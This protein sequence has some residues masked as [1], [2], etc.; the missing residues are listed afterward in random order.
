MTK[1]IHICSLNCQGLRVKDKRHRLYLW[2]KYQKC[3]ILFVQ[4]SHFTEDLEKDLNSEIKDQQY[5]S[6]GT[7]QSRGVSIFI[8]NDLECKFI[9]IFKDQEGRLLLINIEIEDSIYTLVNVYAPNIPKNRNIFFKKV[10]E[11]I[12]KNS[13]GM[14]IIGGD[15]ND[16]LTKIDKKNK[17]STQKLKQTKP[18]FSLKSLIKT[19]KLSD[20]WREIHGKEIQFTWRRKNNLN[21]ASRIDFFLTCPEIRTKIE[22]TDIRPAIITHTD[23][24]AISIKIKGRSDQ[25]GKGYFKINNSILEN[26]EYQNLIKILIKQYEKKILL[27]NDIGVK[28][29]LFK[30]EVRDHTIAFCK[31]KAQNNVKD[32]HI[33]ENKLKKLN[34]GINKKCK[35]D[36]INSL[37]EEINI[38]EEKLGKLYDS[39]TKGA[40]IRSR[41][42]WVEEG[43]KNTKFFLGLEKARQ[44]RKT[45]TALRDKEGVIHTHPTEILNIEKEFYEEIYKSSNP[46]KNSIKDYVMNTECDHVL[47]DKESDS[48]EGLLSTQECTDSLFKMKLNKAP[49][50]DGLSVEF[51]RTFWEHLKEFAVKTFNLSFD[52]G[53]LTNSQK[54]GVISLLHKKNDPLSLDN[55]RPITLLNVDT[56]LVAYSLAQRIIK[57]LPQIIH[58]DQNGYVKNRYIGYNIR[59]IQDVIDYADKFN[60][61]GALLFLDF[62]KAFDSLEWDFMFFALQKFGFKNSMMRWIKLL[63]TDIKSSV[64]NNGWISKPMSIYRGIRQGCPCSA[65]IFVIAV[66]ILACKIRQDHN[67]KG[68]EIKIDGKTHTLKISQLADDTT[69]FLKSKQDISKALNMIEKFGSL[70]GLK[71]NRSKT[72]GIWLG[73]QKHCKEKYE[74][75]NFTEK[76]IKSLGIYFGHNKKECQKLNFDKQLEKTVKI[77]SNWK[78]RN[79]T[80]IGRITVIKSLIIP[81]ITYLATVSTLSKEYLDKFKKIIYEFLWNNKTEKVKRTVLSYNQLAGGLKMV[82]IDKY[83]E[84]IKIGWIKRLT[85]DKFLN[86]MVIPKFYLNK[87]GSNLLILRMN[88]NNIYSIPGTKELPEFYLDMIKVWLKNKN[89]KTKNPNNYRLIRQE[90]IWGNQLIKFQKKTLLFQNWIDSNIIHINDIIDENGVFSEKIISLKL[91]NKSNWIAEFSRLRKAIPK[92]WLKILNEECSIKTSVLINNSLYISEKNNCQHKLEKLDSKKIYSILIEYDKEVPIGY[93]KWNRI[94]KCENIQIEAQYVQKFIHNYLKDNKLKMCRWKLLH[95]ILPNKVLLKQWKISH[96]STCN[97]CNVTEDYKHFFVTCHFLDEFWG[98]IY[99]ILELV[100]IGRHILTEKNLIWGYKINDEH[101]YEI[102]FLLTVIVFTIHKI[103]YLSEY[104]TQNINIYNVFRSEFKIGLLLQKKYI[105]IEGKGI[106]EKI[107]SYI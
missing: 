102:N 12:T 65:I 95:F 37:K 53:E 42:K 44:T 85:A 58:G 61:E 82:N 75:I 67:L 54:L 41:I 48:M 1:T 20:I 7:S 63:Y 51:Y 36:D 88:T 6:F 56:K 57:V 26:E 90:V 78:K 100:K 93:H 105:N 71:L 4:E 83:I 49:G 10:K 80:M 96:N 69:L 16:T 68:F 15:M 39:K 5:H 55:Y 22:S 52:K 11:I 60:I 91:K 79:L 47:T 73:K 101:Y 87:F 35:I 21:E 19:Q 72:E 103:H 107:Y 30:T 29:D 99:K 70:S 32:I 84:S 2:M 17:V 89:N 64:L 106:L 74:N 31:R 76:P 45:I 94:L 3:N 50:I 8:N 23:H 92:E 77:I 25:K 43:E 14:V 62:S 97:F 33:L 27:T 40:Q 38:I 34:K 24:Q 104:R 13:L 46:D 18:V 81:I 98:E 9:N 59:Q 66:E 86:W 28:W